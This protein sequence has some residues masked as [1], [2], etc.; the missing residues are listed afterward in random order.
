MKYT[1]A[2]TSGALA[3][4]LATGAWA[5]SVTGTVQHIDPA[6]RIVHFTD[7]RILHLE[8]GAVI[9]IDGREVAFD[10]VR[11]GMVAEVQRRTAPA[12]QVPAAPAPTRAADVIQ[13]H[14]PV[15]VSGTVARFD[16]Q[17]RVITFQDGRMVRLGDRATVWQAKR[18]ADVRQG[19]H[20]YVENAHPMGFQAAT[21]AAVPQG[22]Q[23]MGTV[24]RVD[25]GKAEL[26]LADGRVVKISP[27]TRMHMHDRAMTLADLQP[28]DQLVIWVRDGQPT[29]VAPAPG[30]VVRERPG[31]APAALPREG[32]APGFHGAVID[33]QE[34]RI[35][36]HPQAP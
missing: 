24:T 6:G 7:G 27:A 22:R 2:V 26:V 34:I 8:E 28:G 3:L 15:S 21:G 31:D 12:A 29:A 11:P 36:R 33:A 20:V 14:P 25:A 1:M 13:D 23:L 17:N 30:V 32:L 35:Y 19:E 10:Q 16:E 9:L 18:L 5:Q 4:L